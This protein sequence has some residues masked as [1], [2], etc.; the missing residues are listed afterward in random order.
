MSCACHGA[1][2]NGRPYE[3]V[4]QSI[5]PPYTFHVTLSTSEKLELGT[6]RDMYPSLP[7]CRG[8]DATSWFRQ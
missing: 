2:D 7:S 8:S 4:S 6:I 5:S 3:S 1:Q